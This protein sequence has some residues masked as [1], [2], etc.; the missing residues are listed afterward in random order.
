MYCK[1]TE[2]EFKLLRA[3]KRD[4]MLFKKD[5]EAAAT[6]EE[7]DGAMSGNRDNSEENLCSGRNGR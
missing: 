5:K 6:S 4:V 7:I 2:F 1:E 3:W